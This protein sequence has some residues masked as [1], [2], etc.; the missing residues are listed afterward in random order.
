MEA[1]D[2]RALGVTKPDL[3]NDDRG[4][5]YDLDERDQQCAGGEGDV[6]RKRA[7]EESDE[8][9]EKTTVRFL[10]TDRE[11]TNVGPR[12]GPSPISKTDQRSHPQQ[13]WDP[14]NIFVPRDIKKSFSFSGYGLMPGVKNREEISFSELK[15]LVEEGKKEPTKTTKQKM[16]EFANKYR[17]FRPVSVGR[18]PW[19]R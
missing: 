17:D 18:L 10:V 13:L 14:S 1:D 19:Y 16:K 9:S 15:L 2:E 7:L 8:E 6:L 12:V 11:G 5:E 3:I 4:S